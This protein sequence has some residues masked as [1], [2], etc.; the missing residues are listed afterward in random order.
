MIAR[1]TILAAAMLLGACQTAAVTEAPTPAALRGDYFLWHSQALGRPLHIHVALPENYATETARTYP[2]V[3]LTDGDSLFP[4]LAPTH[5]FLSYDEPV[6]PAIIVG[7]AYGTFGEGNMRRTDYTAPGPD[8]PEASAHT[9]QR[10]LADELI[11]EIE[12]RYRS[13]AE[14]RVLVGQSRG[15]TFVVYSA[16]TAPDLFWG[17]IASNPAFNLNRDAYHATPSPAARRDLSLFVAS[18]SRDRPALRTGALEWFE[19]WNART[20]LPWRLN[21]VTIEDG[22]H[23]ADMGEVYSDGMVWLFR[24]EAR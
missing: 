16:I 21:T 8:M 24:D 13:N 12:R 6:P 11:P 10:F 4:M 17:R 23:A 5:L 19:H 20:Q 14:R 3:Y 9:Y 22:T 2:T 15:A 1:R 18:G 7:I